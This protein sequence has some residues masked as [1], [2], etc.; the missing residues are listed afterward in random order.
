MSIIKSFVGG[1]GGQIASVE[2]RIWSILNIEMK[3][4]FL[5][6]ILFRCSYAFCQIDTSGIL[7][8]GHIDLVITQ[9]S[10]T[11]VKKQILSIVNAN[12]E[13]DYTGLSISGD[14]D[15]IPYFVFY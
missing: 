12:R 10:Y 7:Y 3:G 8:K 2:W 11:K 13:I 5:F 15:S 6:L 14:F 1:R 9:K 4:L